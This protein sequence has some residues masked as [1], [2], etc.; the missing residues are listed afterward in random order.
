MT[1]IRTS[2]SSPNPTL[3]APDSPPPVLAS[4]HNKNGQDQ[5][6]TIALDRER[7]PEPLF[8]QETDCNLPKPLISLHG[9]WLREA[10][11]VP[12]DRIRVRV[13]PGCLVITRE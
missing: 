12:C 8:S 1:S 13:M 10:G 2:K 3:V 6:L 5:W 9:A 7:H 11:F 4:L